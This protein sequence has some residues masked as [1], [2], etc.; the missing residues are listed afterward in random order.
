MCCAQKS[1]AVSPPPSFCVVA[2]P[3]ARLWEDY[4]VQPN[5]AA[6]RPAAVPF[7]QSWESGV[8][9]V[10]IRPRAAPARHDL[11]CDPILWFCHAARPG[12]ISASRLLVALES[13][14]GQDSND[15]PKL[16]ARSLFP[17]VAP[18]VAVLC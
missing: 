13:S 15:K 2:R 8:S 5:P 4:P 17:A 16:Q 3:T 12:F 18:R 11:A 1:G 10:P 14:H 7:L 6:G 9:G